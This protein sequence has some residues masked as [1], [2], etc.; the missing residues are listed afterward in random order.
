MPNYRRL[1]H[2]GG[3]YFFTIN[4]LQ[5][6]GNEILTENIE[7][8]RTVVK[9]VRQ[10]YPFKIHA[11][12]VLPDHLHC[13]IELPDHDSDF[14]TRIR[15]IKFGFSRGLPTKERLSTVRQKRGERG[16]WQR[17]F[18]EHLVKDEHDYS[19]HM[20]YVHYNPV[21]HGYVNQVSD[22]PYST[23]HNLVEE[24]VYPDDWAGSK[25]ADSLKCP[26]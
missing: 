20:D 19:A 11:W 9:Q 4:T 3:T 24:D 14:S 7:L 2:P 17:R 10:K 8:L 15:L 21:K 22:W 13:I 23:F 26:D 12:V 25:I 1:F 6:R 5:R 16:I 18:W